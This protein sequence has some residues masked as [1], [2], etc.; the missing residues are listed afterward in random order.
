[1][2]NEWFLFRLGV[3]SQLMRCTDTVLCKKVPTL[4]AC[5]VPVLGWTPHL[6]ARVCGPSLFGFVK[7]TGAGS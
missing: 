2:E 3:L 1:M 6:V 7:Q 5:D 4:L